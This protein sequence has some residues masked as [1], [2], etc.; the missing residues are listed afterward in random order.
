MSISSLLLNALKMAV[1]SVVLLLD[2]RS[3]QFL[4][5]I[6][7]LC[8]PVIRGC[9]L[10]L[11]ANSTF[12]YSLVFR[13]ICVPICFIQGFQ[14]RGF[15]YV[16]YEDSKYEGS[17]MFHYEGSDMFHTRVPI[18]FIRG[19]RYVSYEDSDMFHTRIPI[20]FIRGFR[21]VSYEDSDMFHARIPICFMRGFRSVSC[22]DS[23]MFHTRVPICFIRGIRY[24]S[25]EDSDMFHTRFVCP[26][27][28]T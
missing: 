18:C 27:V 5:K 24:V 20:C 8:I 17:D 12:C 15:W 19:F 13:K 25:Y 4:M 21:Y 6:Q 16:S 10:R 23:D 3:N 11:T 1:C 14:I 28:G 22:E 7:L 2:F 26:P 9:I